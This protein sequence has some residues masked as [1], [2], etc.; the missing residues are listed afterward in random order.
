MIEGDEEMNKLQIFRNT[1]F[2]ELPKKEVDN[3]S[4]RVYIAEYGDFIKIGSTKNAKERISALAR[5][6]RY[7]GICINRIALTIPHTNYVKNEKKMH[8]KLNEYRVGNTELFNVDF[9]NAIMIIE[10]LDFE[11][12]SAELENEA[13]ERFKFLMEVVKSV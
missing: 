6:A 8:I 3:F 1:D 2:G 7:D 11:L 5:Q 9:E 10:N 12:K 13:N 4:G